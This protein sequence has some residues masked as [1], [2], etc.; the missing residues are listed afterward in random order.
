MRAVTLFPLIDS[1]TGPAAYNP[2]GRKSTV[3]KG[4]R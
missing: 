2:G 3:M 1:G 4:S